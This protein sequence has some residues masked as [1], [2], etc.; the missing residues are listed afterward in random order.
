M[1]TGPL[2]PVPLHLRNAPTRL[3]KNLGY[4]K[5]YKYNPAYKEPVEQDYLPEELKGIDFFTERKTWPPC[6]EWGLILWF[7]QLYWGGNCPYGFS[8]LL[9]WSKVFSHWAFR[10]LSYPS[11]FTVVILTVFCKELLL[12]SIERQKIS[13]I[14][15]SPSGWN[16]VEKK[17]ET[18]AAVKREILLCCVLKAVSISDFENVCFPENSKSHPPLKYGK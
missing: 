17:W 4:G 13:L 6:S 8:H 2:P 11:G 1:H 3:M 16:E 9:L 10:V 7:T 15:L 18:C 5:G 14:V 12:G